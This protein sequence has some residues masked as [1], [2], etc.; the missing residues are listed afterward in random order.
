[1]VSAHASAEFCMSSQSQQ[2]NRLNRSPLYSY[3]MLQ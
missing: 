2:H 3:N 1:M